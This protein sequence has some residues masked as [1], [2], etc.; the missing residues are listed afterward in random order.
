MSNS[1]NQSV[2]AEDL[3]TEEEIQ[4]ELLNTEGISCLALLYNIPEY[5]VRRAIKEG[6]SLKQLDKLLDTCYTVI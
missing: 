1:L 2:F 6:C 4:E 5:K 3:K